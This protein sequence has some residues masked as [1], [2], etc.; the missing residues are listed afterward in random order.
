MIIAVQNVL[1]AKPNHRKEATS[2]AVVPQVQLDVGPR[3]REHDWSDAAWG[4]HDPAVL[5]VE[6]K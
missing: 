2:L 5:R 3:F 4:A 1:D 6:S